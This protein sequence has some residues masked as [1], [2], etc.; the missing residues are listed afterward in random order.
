MATNSSLKN[1]ISKSN[2]NNQVSNAKQ[3]TLKSLL[4][5]PAVQKRFE[6]VL[7]E[8]ASG[9]TTS[10][11][12][13]VNG[14]P[15]LA[16][17][18]PMSII[19]SAMVAATLD[20]PIDKNL[21]YAYIV[22]FRDWKKGNEKVAQFQLGY[23]GYIQLAQRSG[24]YMALNVT[25]VYEGELK[26]WNRLTEEFEFDPEGKESDEVIGYVAYFRLV[27]G[28]EKTVY[29][30]KQQVEMHRVKHNKSKNKEQLT[31]VWKSD[32]D[33]MAQKTVL[34]NMLSKWGILSIEM[35]KAVTTDETVQEMDE[36]GELKQAEMIE[37]DES[38]QET[39]NGPM[40]LNDEESTELFKEGTI[41][42][43]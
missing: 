32:Y 15:N 12:N 24:Q 10:L 41:T 25:E 20:L 40:D 26:S 2:G 17:A 6:A 16:E 29:W 35:Q 28:F 37:D 14:D 43:K 9:F 42:P 38:E 22:P 7:E 27:N 11:L 1:Q 3:M 21:G 5:S 13:M 23:K 8:K 36:K 31:G 33:A 19:T 39:I 34:K 4:S 18:Q 30:T